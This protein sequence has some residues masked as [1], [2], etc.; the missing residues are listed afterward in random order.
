MMLPLLT[1]SIVLIGL[2]GCGKS[3]LGQLLATHYGCPYIDTDRSIESVAGCSLQTVL[4]R[5]GVQAMRDLEGRVVASLRVDKPAL[6][7]TGGSVVYAPS[8]MQHL[9]QLGMVIYLR[10]TEATIV[11]RLGNYSD[12]GIVRRPE[13]SLSNVI[14]E[15][16][17][18][19]ECYADA[20]L[21]VDTLSVVAAKD[22]LI[23]IING[24]RARPA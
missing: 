10:A 14:A 8:A 1:E 18:L 16:L 7:S 12:R 9:Q 23:D 17:P 21:D 4:D 20:V 15:R 6:I 22:A 3:T 2:P 19:Y 11:Q 24:N 5:D 13:Q